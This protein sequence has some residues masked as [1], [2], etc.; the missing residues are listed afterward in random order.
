MEEIKIYNN[1]KKEKDVQKIGR[2]YWHK[3]LYYTTKMLKFESFEFNIIK[4]K[5]FSFIV[6]Q[7]MEF[8]DT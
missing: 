2:F 4:T 8:F 7:K 5:E 6:L 1:D 3:R